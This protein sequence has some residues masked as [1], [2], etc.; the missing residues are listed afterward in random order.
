MLRAAFFAAFAVSATLV[1]ASTSSNVIT[2]TASNFDSIVKAES[3]ILVKFFGTPKPWCIRCEDP[4]LEYEEA[5]TVLKNQ[6]IKLAKVNCDQEVDL[7]Q[8]KNIYKYP[9]LRLFRNDTQRHVDYRGARQAD[10]IVQYMLTQSLP[11]VSIVTMTNHVQTIQ[12]VKHITIVAYISSSTDTLASAFRSFAQDHRDGL[13]SSDPDHREEYEFA[14][15]TDQE[16][17]NAAG[18]VPP[19]IVAYRAFDEPKAEYHGALLNLRPYE[20]RAWLAE[21]NIP[22][23][24]RLTAENYGIYTNSDKPLATLCLDPHDSE[25][26]ALLESLRPTAL[27]YKSSLYITWLDTAAFRRQCEAVLQRRHATWPAFIIRD[28]QKN[29]IYPLEDSQPMT[30]E[31]VEGWIQRF[32]NGDLSPLVRSAPIPEAQ[33]EPVFN[34]VSKQFDEVVF[35][36]SKDVFL[37]IYSTWCGHCKVMKPAWD[38]LGEKYAPLKD[39]V[40]IAKI[41]L[42]DNDLPPSAPFKVTGF[43]T[44]KFKPAGTRD[45]IDY[46]ERRS[47]YSFSAFVEKHAKNDLSLPPSELTSL[48][49]GSQA[50][51][52]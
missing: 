7:C 27:K 29:A 18:I 23:I 19:A 42:V 30:P 17:A 28:V 3:L 11:A 6:D 8:A 43:P 4:I 25:N 41:N 26:D 40:V 35:D 15:S 38:A 21:L 1:I 13:H 10:S 45:F 34:L 33:D 49:D 50:P 32:L 31:V 16:V 51:L 2:L 39:K 20:L 37:E 47:L 44:L 22:A 24:T 9:I 5:A 14:L 46:T 52:V 48:A 12:A 36:E